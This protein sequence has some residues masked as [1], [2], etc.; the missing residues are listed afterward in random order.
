MARINR[1]PQPAD[2]ARQIA[3]LPAH[4]LASKARSLKIR[5]HAAAPGSGPSGETCGSCLH[6]YRN[7]MA[8]TY[9]KCY[10]SRARWTGGAATDVKARDPA[11][12]K[13][14]RKIT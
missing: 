12:E 3:I 8:S 14:E 10:L 6:L 1:P 9:L 7:Q 4:V 13:W 5:G 2:D 11:C